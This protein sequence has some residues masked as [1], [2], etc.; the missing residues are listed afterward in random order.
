MVTT[1]NFVV[2]TKRELLPHLSIKQADLAR[3]LGISREAVS[4]WPLDKPIPEA[5]MLRIRY[6]LFPE[7]F[8]HVQEA[9]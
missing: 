9:V 8:Q 3:R 2:M 7:K 6:E 5:K 4:Q 1:L